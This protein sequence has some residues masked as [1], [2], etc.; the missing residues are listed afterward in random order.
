MILNVDSTAAPKQYSEPM[1]STILNKIVHFLDLTLLKDAIYVNIVI[2]FSFTIF[3]DSIFN[4]LLPIFL[5][6]KGFSQVWSSL[7]LYIF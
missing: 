4:A 2:G 1:R 5:I 7:I 3:S 6:E